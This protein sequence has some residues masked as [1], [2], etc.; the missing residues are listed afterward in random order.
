MKALDFKHNFIRFQVQQCIDRL[1]IHDRMSSLPFLFF[2]LMHFQ[3]P[4]NTFRA[5]QSQT[6]NWTLGE[7][8]NEGVAL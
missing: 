7:I 6:K 1:N 3:F 8:I 4:G 2:S 5:L